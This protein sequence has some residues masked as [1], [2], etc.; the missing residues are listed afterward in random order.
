M[1]VRRACATLEAGEANR[2]PRAPERRMHMK[3]L[4]FVVSLVLIGLVVGLGANSIG[5]ASASTSIDTSVPNDPVA[6]ATPDTT[7]GTSTVVTEK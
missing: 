7:G 1:A 6:T 5:R 3:R 2:R 4:G